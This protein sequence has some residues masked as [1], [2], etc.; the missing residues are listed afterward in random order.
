MKNKREE[1]LYSLLLLLQLYNTNNLC[2]CDTNSHSTSSLR[3]RASH[4]DRD[5]TRGG[6]EKSERRGEGYNF[7][8]K[9]QKVVY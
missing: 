6:K 3:R 4:T 5:K 8:W 9:R 2:A 7:D 1:G